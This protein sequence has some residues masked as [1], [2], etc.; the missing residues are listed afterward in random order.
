MCAQPHASPIAAAVW[1]ARICE[2]AI[3]IAASIRCAAMNA[4]TSLACAWPASDPALGV[5]LRLTVTD[6]ENS[7]RHGRQLQA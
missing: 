1:C 4:A 2:L 3:R 6:E 7:A 5:G